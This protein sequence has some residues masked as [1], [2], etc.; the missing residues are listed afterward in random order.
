MSR[1]TGALS[2]LLPG[3][4]IKAP[5]GQGVAMMAVVE[6]TLEAMQHVVDLG[7][8]GLLE[9]GSGIQR[10]IAGAADQHDGARGMVGT[11]QPLDLTDELRVDLPVRAII[12]ADMM[13]ANRMTDEQV[14]HLAAAVDKQG[15]R[16]TGKKRCRV[17]RAEMF[18]TSRSEEHTSELQSH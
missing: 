11:G 13:G 2:A 18:H 5:T 1:A 16:L 3:Q 4:A 12:P 17:F 6:L 8:A 7:K 15:I 9:R 10:A 14:F